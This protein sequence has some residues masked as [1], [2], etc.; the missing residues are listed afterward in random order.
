MEMGNPHLR[1]LEKENGLNSP[2]GYLTNNEQVSYIN[3]ILMFLKIDLTVK[4]PK[5]FS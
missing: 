3:P 4:A 2:L 5:L 1:N